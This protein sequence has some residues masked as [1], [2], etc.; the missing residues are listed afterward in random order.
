MVYK[1]SKYNVALASKNVGLTLKTKKKGLNHF[2]WFGKG[3]CLTKF[4]GLK[5]I[6]WTD[7]KIKVFFFSLFSKTIAEFSKK[8]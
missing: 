1:C 3:K 7:R 2:D 6:Y 8:K 5:R 4:Y